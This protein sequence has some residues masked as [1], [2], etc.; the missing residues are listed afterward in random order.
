MLPIKLI[1]WVSLILS[2]VWSVRCGDDLLKLDI[3]DNHGTQQL[4]KAF[5]DEPKEEH[6][7]DRIADLVAR[8]ASEESRQEVDPF[9]A[10]CVHDFSLPCPESW[11]K[12]GTLCEAPPSYK[13]DC[14]RSVDTTEFTMEQK[15][16]FMTDCKVRWPCKVTADKTD[17]IYCNNTERNF[18][19]PCPENFLRHKQESGYV[20]VPDFSGYMGPC[21]SVVDFTNYSKEAKMLWAKTCGTTWPCMTICPW[22]FDKCPMDWT[23]ASD[24]ACEAPASYKGPCEK[25]IHFTYYTQEMKRNRLIECDIPFECSTDCRKDYN[26]CP[27][28]WK[29]EADGYC[30]PNSGMLNC[31]DIIADLFKQVGKP[32]YRTGNTA[33]DLRALDVESKKLFESK[34]RTVEFPCIEDDDEINWSLTCPRT[35]TIARDDLKSC[36]PPLVNDDDVCHSPVTFNN[37]EEKRAFASLCQINWSGSNKPENHTTA[38]KATQENYSGP[39]NDLGNVHS[40]DKPV[41]MAPGT[42][43][44]VKEEATKRRR[45][46]PKEKLVTMKHM[47]NIFGMN[48][49]VV[50]VNKNQNRRLIKG[51]T[52]E[53]HLLPGST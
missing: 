1:S 39:I 13:G 29:S 44:G 23:Q 6:I 9:T 22:V 43:K 50:K 7:S 28:L 5:K 16:L 2:V 51:F 48:P 31:R 49:Y 10:Q 25:R 17:A 53:V 41:H 46:S 35:W 36:H 14:K 8:T 19:Q 40:L 4:Y 47:A 52:R 45:N 37:E 32:Q 30:A 3:P 20:C 42:S 34:C 33:I 27:V 26:K 38:A 21:N 24:G 11:V 18:L 12:S 15:M